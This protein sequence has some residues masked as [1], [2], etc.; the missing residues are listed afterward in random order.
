LAQEEARH[1]TIVQ[2]EYNRLTMN[3]DWDRYRIWREVL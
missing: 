2:D 3:P 1:R